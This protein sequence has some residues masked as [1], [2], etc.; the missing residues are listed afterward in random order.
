MS[1]RHPY[2]DICLHNL[3]RAPPVL[4]K[5]AALAFEIVCFV[6]GLSLSKGF[7]L[8]P[9]QFKTIHRKAER[10]SAGYL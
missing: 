9:P 5:Y 4:F 7:Q 6:S 2:L 8:T 3:A 1:S 10:K